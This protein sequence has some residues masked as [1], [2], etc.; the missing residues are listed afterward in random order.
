MIAWVVFKEN[1]DRQ[2]VLGMIA[3]VAGGLML[4]WQPGSLQMSTGA[5]LIVGACLCWAVDN[6]LTHKVSSN[7]A[8]LLACIKGLVA[9]LCNT[10]LALEHGAVLPPPTVLAG[11][12][13]C[14]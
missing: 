12:V 2:I 9:G 4:S 3:I 1:A 11:A 5:L 13:L 10:V 14:A 8:L 7:D 6:N